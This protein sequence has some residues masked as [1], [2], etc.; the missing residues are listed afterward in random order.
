MTTA[1]DFIFVLS[2]I[3][4]IPTRL[5]DQIILGVNLFTGNSVMIH[6]QSLLGKSTIL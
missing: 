1:V 4:H 3:L 6:Y 5:D 2:N